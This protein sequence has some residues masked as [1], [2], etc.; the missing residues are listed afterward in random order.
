MSNSL[1]SPPSRQAPRLPC[2]SRIAR[3]DPLGL[4]SWFPEHPSRSSSSWS[5]SCQCWLSLQPWRRWRLLGSPPSRCWN[6][7][8]SS[9][10]PVEFLFY[11][12]RTLGEHYSIWILRLCGKGPPFALYHCLA[13]MCSNMFARIPLNYESCKLWAVVDIENVNFL[14]S[15]I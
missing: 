9:P 7:V 4:A 8:F 13:S 2:P 10:S 5:C 15:R 6:W 3:F 11:P 14:Q 12:A 1:Q